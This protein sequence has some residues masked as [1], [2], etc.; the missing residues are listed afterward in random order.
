MFT[1]LL[2]KQFQEIFKGYFYDAKKNQMR[3]KGSIIA[4]FAFFAIIIFGVFGS[5][6]VSLAVTLCEP[7][8]SANA[9]WLYFAITAS[10]AILVGVFGTV[11]TG[12]TALFLAKD[13][14]LLLSLP[15]PVKDIVAARLMSTFLLGTLYTA[16]ALVPALVVYWRTKSSG[17]V[18]VLCGIALLVIA[19][20][21]VLCI[22]CLLSWIVAKIA[23]RLENKSLLS[24]LII[25]MFI[26]LYY[27]VYFQAGEAM[28]EL[29]ANAATYSASV[30]DAAY[31]VYLF[32]S[33][34][35][36]N[37]TAMIVFLAI[38]IVLVA[39]TW[40][41]LSR[42]YLGIVTASA[43]TK[44]VRYVEKTA[45]FKSSFSALLGKEF[46]KFRSSAN[47]MLNSN[48]GSL[49]MLVIGIATLVNAQSI[50]ELVA[51]VWGNDLTFVC[52]VMCGALCMLAGTNTIAAPSVSLEGKS[53]WIL[54]SL[55]I[56]P[57]SVLRAKAVMHFI[58]TAVPLAIAVVCFA[59]ALD[60]PAAPKTLMCIVPFAYVAFTSMA[61]SFLGVKMANVAWTNELMPLKRSGAVIALMFGGWGI[62]MVFIVGFV[63]F[64]SAVDATA[65]MAVWA[66][67]FLA[68]AAF[69]LHWLDTKGSQLFSEL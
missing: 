19:A 55:P 23:L 42:S 11:A 18:E 54:Q 36:G 57:K 4:W 45:S 16:I 44:R 34:G 61:G 46:A 2:K 15:I 25:V 51:D 50:N 43:K 17:I 47:Y 32:G 52:V 67:L 20:A 68:I 49:F 39:L 59:I 5:M 48:M 3:S 26:A 13:N 53:I 10:T 58:L 27:F 14:D 66:V 37:V 22:G 30:K 24:V 9:G 35:E 69:L 56:A 60:L 8:V 65:Y 38:A 62:A 21:V 29:L 64:G 12:Y 41:A 28:M 40:V 63:I 33:I 6:F 31:G 7:L 1:I